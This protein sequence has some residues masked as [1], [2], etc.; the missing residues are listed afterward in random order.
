MKSVL[1]VAA[2]LSALALHSIR[3]F[4]Q[5]HEDC[6]ALL[7][8]EFARRPDPADGFVTN[9]VPMTAETLLA[10]YRRGIF[11]WNTFPNGNPGWYDPPLRGVL[12]FSS[13]RIPKSDK[14]GSAGRS[15]RALTASPR[16]WRSSK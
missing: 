2:L 11:P 15:A 6:S 13:L 14:S 4:S 16:T 12:D 9:N 3:A 10:A 1:L 8:A 5:S 7:R